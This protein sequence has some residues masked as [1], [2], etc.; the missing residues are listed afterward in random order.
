M[1]EPTADAQ[2]PAAPPPGPGTA[3]GEHGQE[4]PGTA[5]SP[6]GEN[7]EE[8]QPLGIGVE[9]TGHEG[10]D[11]RLRRLADAGRLA[12][13]GHPEVYEEVHGALRETLAALD[14]RP[15]PRPPGS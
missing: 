14:E 2:A 3:A 5:G 9:P 15:G 6:G 1:H 12:V 10:V 13:S 11:A 8:P 7:G 4:D